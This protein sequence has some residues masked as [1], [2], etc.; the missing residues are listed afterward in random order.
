MCRRDAEDSRPTPSP[1]ADGF[2]NLIRPTGTQGLADAVTVELP[3]RRIE[4]GADGEAHVAPL[5]VLNG[6]GED[7][8]C[9]VVDV[10][11]GRAVQDHPPQ[12]AAVVDQG[13]D[14]LRELARIGEV[15]ARTEPADDQSL[16]GAGAGLYR[17]GPH[18]TER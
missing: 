1:T 14:I 6:L 10:F 8:G 9:G 3:L 18:V 16:L 7:L 4:D 13:R 17:N 5:D 11:D 12:R 2:V 15:Q